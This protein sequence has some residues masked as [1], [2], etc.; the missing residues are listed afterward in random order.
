MCKLAISLPDSQAFAR[1]SGDFNPLHVDP[2]A[3]RRLQFGSCVVHGVHVSLAMLQEAVRGGLFGDAPFSLSE[4]SLLFDAPLRS[5]QEFEVSISKADGRVEAIASVGGRILQRATFVAGAND[6]RG[7]PADHAFTMS[8]AGEYTFEQMDSAAGTAQLALDR[9]LAT[10]LLPE[11]S[12]DRFS[13][14]QFATMLAATRIVGMQRPGL[15][16]V[17]TE[18]K[19]MFGSTDG[20]G[21]SL[22]W[23]VVKA[24]RR[25]N[26]VTMALSGAATGV[27]AAIV[28]SS[29]MQQASY[30][31]IKA[32]TREGVRSGQRVL[33]VGGSRGIG[34]AAAKILA[35]SGADVTIT[36]AAGSDDA[37]RVCG[38]I[39]AGGGS[40]RAVHLDVRDALS[41]D[42]APPPDQVFYFASPTIVVSPDANWRSE[43]FAQYVAF[44]V[45]GFAR[46]V[47]WAIQSRP[48]GARD[49]FVY[50]PSTGFLD[51]PIRGS[52]EYCAAKAAGEAMA[53][54]W[55]VSRPGLRIVCSRLP[56][57][58]TDQTAAIRS[59]SIPTASEYMLK[60]LAEL[61]E[62]T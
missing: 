40:C 55:R 41:S 58:L 33:V 22:E 16:S 34:E 30:L 3:A 6:R 44:Y 14:E 37:V 21:A 13:P 20:A 2:V 62:P 56:R 36:Y 23:R 60:A 61:E 35:A 28:R 17:F 10:E 1:L 29:P 25:F 27:I 19:L 59:A 54:A 4:A 57:L 32:Q 7:A 45:D 48:G 12:A 31:D 43:L 47:D 24:D 11:L 46:V 9:K 15:H 42:F 39:V 5:G 50:Y 49:L 26:L 38:E 53:A 52:A 18:L 51:A 8:A